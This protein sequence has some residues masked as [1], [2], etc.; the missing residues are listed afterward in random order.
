MPPQTFVPIVPAPMQ[1][2]PRTLNSVPMMT[3]ALNGIN[4]SMEMVPNGGHGQIMMPQ[5]NVSFGPTTPVRPQP[6]YYPQF[7][8]SSQ[9][10]I[11]PAQFGSPMRMRSQRAH[12]AQTSQQ[13]T[14]FPQG[15][16]LNKVGPLPQN[17]LS[18]PQAQSAD[19]NLDFDV[20]LFQDTM[21]APA[22]PPLSNNT[23]QVNNADVTFLPDAQGNRSMFNFDDSV[24]PNSNTM[25]PCSEDLFSDNFFEL[26]K[27]PSD[28]TFQG[29]TQNGVPAP[30]MGMNA[31][32][33]NLEC[34]F[35]EQ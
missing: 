9:S 3:G 11:L 25:G 23:P 32:Q 21:S 1:N 19:F 22:D 5:S 26:S 24:M 14:M 4:Q 17:N 20:Q 13:H 8:M 2:A 31:A 6:Q 10:G 12:S 30:S 28:A 34:R 27:H 16:G 33:A 35:G 15:V 7:L 29:Q 18:A